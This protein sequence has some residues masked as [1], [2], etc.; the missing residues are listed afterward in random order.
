MR[1]IKYHESM[2]EHKKIKSFMFNFKLDNKKCNN[3]IKTAM[4]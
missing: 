3:K 1:S 4:N 2:I